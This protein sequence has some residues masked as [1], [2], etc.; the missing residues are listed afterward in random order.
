[1]AERVEQLR[2]RAGSAD[3]DLDRVID[4]LCA[5]SNQL[6][7]GQ[8]PL[9]RAL[10]HD[11]AES[12]Q[13]HPAMVEWGLSSTLG[14]VQPAVLRR[15]AVLARN[16][17]NALAAPHRLVAVVLAGNVFSAAVRA[18]FLPLLAGANVIAKAAKHDDVLPRMIKRL[19]DDMDP[20]I[21]QRLA[22]V[23]FSR[24]DTAATAALL[25][26]ADAVSAY[27]DDSTLRH[28]AGQVPAGARFIPHGHGISAVYIGQE[29]LCSAAKARDIADRVAL[30]VAAYDQHGCLSPHTV[31][32][33]AGAA[34]DARSFA[35]LL[36]HESLPLLAELLPRGEQ[37]SAQHAA[38][39]QWCAV[40][41]ARGELFAS[42]EHAV[43]FEHDLSARPSP[44]GR[45]ISV[46][47]C[48]GPD[49]LRRKLEA[50]GPQLK[51]LGVAGPHAERVRIATSLRTVSTA[52]V[53]RVGEMQTPPFDAYADGRPPLEGLFDFIEVR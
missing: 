49:A 48:A 46:H 15:L 5:V 28:L 2:S 27:G 31:F 36:A 52:R 50:F 33:E 16:A 37:S 9:A 34:T 38:G 53:C 39:L 25:A 42:P 7:R 23:Q 51:S 12:T 14:S 30:D 29:Q 18:L 26:H 32:V 47:S 6:I 45:M 3:D 44:G 35:R 11:L 41:A 20:A 13:L 1:V 22:V 17:P 8:A 43:S 19:L 10:R 40:A 4:A 21:G 24:H